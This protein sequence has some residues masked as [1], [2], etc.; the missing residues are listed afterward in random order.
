MHK[1][2]L[3][4]AA[5]TPPVTPANPRKNAEEALRLIARTDGA[6]LIVLP[7]LSVTGYTC[8]DLFLHAALL[9]AAEEALSWL[10]QKTKASGALIAAGLP[11]RR[12][13]V[14]YNCA[15][16]FQNG[17]L[18]GVVPGNRVDLRTFRP[19]AGLSG[20]VSLCGEDIP[21]GADLLFDGGGDF[22]VSFEIGNDVSGGSGAAVI[23]NLAALEEDAG[24]RGAWSDLLRV[25]SAR[26]AAGIV[27]ASAGNGE[28]T[29]DAVYSGVRMI[30]ENGTILAQSGIEENEGVTAIEIDLGLL[31]YERRKTGYCTFTETRG[32]PIKCGGTADKLTRVYSP[33]PFIPEENDALAARCHDVMSVQ[34]R[35]LRTRLSRLP[36]TGL[37]VA[38]SGGLD[39]TLALLAARQAAKQEQRTLLAVTMPGPGTTE[40]T[41]SN[42]EAL[43]NALN[44]PLQTVPIGEAI[45]T[46]LTDI[47]HDGQPDVVFEN[48]QSRERTQIIMDIA[49]AHNSI[50]AGSG[51]LSEIA[52]GFCT[53]GGDQMSMYNVNAGVP[54]TLMRRIIRFV[55]GKS[56]KILRAVLY[57]IV[58][59]PVSPELL[60][61]GSD[62]T[63]DQRSEDILGDYLVHDFYLYWFIRHGYP[64]DKLLMAANRAFEGRYTP[65]SLASVLDVFVT[66]FARSQFKRN[67][68]PDGARIGSVSL[69][70]GD[71]RMPADLEGLL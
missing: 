3:R 31:A 68:M 26:L 64:R 67:A 41:R 54:K 71:W 13:G 25:Q 70:R 4:A 52:L 47:G 63:Q 46:H 18:L 16:V 6:G 59:T 55:A 43:C 40:R 32:I 30:A 60:P 27:S 69:S 42:A 48:A 36:E 66:R 50:V 57:D 10:I 14:L 58:D 65:E 23:G 8:G 61:V 9:D 45:T 7:E 29:G 19:G 35:G 56:P 12:G 15:A 37:V 62:G 53:Y 2:F 5:V 49:N 24:Q 39:S 34:I 33:E 21:F 17:R 1:D 22:S 28:S 20:S 44:V 51:D 11:V 38:V